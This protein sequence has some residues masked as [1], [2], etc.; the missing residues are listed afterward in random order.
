LA[1]FSRIPL[2]N[3]KVRFYSWNKTQDIELG[4]KEVKL[5]L[6]HPTPSLDHLYWT[7]RTSH[8]NFLTESALK[9]AVFG[10]KHKGTWPTEI[11][12]L[13]SPIE[14]FLLNPALVP[15]DFEVGPNIGSDHLPIFLEI[16]VQSKFKKHCK[17]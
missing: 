8:L 15:V 5:H 11:P 3:S 1:E 2:V 9:N 7:L 14:H 12:F 16:A 13:F 4:A 10:L 17:D 6:N